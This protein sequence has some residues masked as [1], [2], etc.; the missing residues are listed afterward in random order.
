MFLAQPK[1]NKYHQNQAGFSLIEVLVSVFLFVIIIIS[2]AEIFRLVIVG[3]RTAISSQN[4]Q[5]SLKYFFEVTGKEMRM[6][7]KNDGSCP[8]INGKIFTLTQNSYGDVLSFKN[9]YQECVTYQIGFDED[10]PRF[11]ITRNGNYGFISPKKIKITHLNFVLNDT[12]LN[13]PLVTIG[14]KAQ[15]IEGNRA[16]SELEIQTSIA[17]RYYQ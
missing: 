4:I 3:Q 7:I 14:I 13:Q 5:E 6:A 9:Y 15:S 17:S 2:A 8:G 12:G 16:P 1:K 10:I 11:Q